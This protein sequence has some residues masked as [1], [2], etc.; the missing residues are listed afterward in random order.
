L[1]VLLPG[2]ALGAA[3]A[4]VSVAAATRYVSLASLAAAVVLCGLQLIRMDNLD[5]ADPRTLFC[6]LAAALVFVKH[7]AN[8]GRLVRGT[9]A[10]IGWGITMRKV[11][12]VVTLGLAF[13]TAVFFT[14]VV[15]PSLISRFEELGDRKRDDRPAWF[16][17]PKGYEH[18]DEAIQ[19]PK[20]QGTRVF[21]YAVE[22]L[23]VWYFLVQ[24]V[25]VFVAAWTAVAWSREH[26]G[27]KVHW[28]RATLLLAA[29]ATV[30][31]G[32]PLE[33]HVS[34]LRE[35]RYQ[36]TDAYLMNPTSPTAL[37]AMQAARAEFGRWHL[38]SLLLNFATIV[39]LTGGMALAGFPP[40]DDKTQAPPP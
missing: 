3:L 31:A 17:L 2:P 16:P 18:S 21:G 4:W 37:A 8:I 30:L 13:G 26:P 32:W 19:G 35:P 36:A 24:G 40:P 33:R 20:E 7:R 5:A 11:L 22:Q 10:T 39:L 38:V 15:A 14:L 27:V 9:E 34:G 1:A 6:V 28:W 12:H 25:C 29:L 23:F